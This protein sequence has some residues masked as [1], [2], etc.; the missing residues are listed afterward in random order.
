M[1][2]SNFRG[3]R[4]IAECLSEP[5]VLCLA[6][7]NTLPSHLVTTVESD[8]MY[9]H[10]LSQHGRHELRYG[11]DGEGCRP[12]PISAVY[13]IFS[14]RAGKRIELSVCSCGVITTDTYFR[15]VCVCR[16]GR[17]EAKCCVYPHR[18]RVWLRNSTGPHCRVGMRERWR[19]SLLPP[20]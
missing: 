1:S 11:C 16:E 18:C 8:F 3:L 6:V 5:C 9:D 10:N 20:F 4:S 2:H 15:G 19:E 17:R 7:C 14:L 12:Q 13:W